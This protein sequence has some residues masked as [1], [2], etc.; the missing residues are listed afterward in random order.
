MGMALLL[1][2]PFLALILIRILWSGSTLW[3]LMAGIIFLGSSA[4]VFLARRNEP[5]YGYQTLAP[6]PNRLPLV[7]LGLGALFLALLILPNVSGDS[8]SSAS[9]LS[10]GNTSQEPSGNLLAQPT[11]RQTPQGQVTVPT[12]TARAQPTAEE[13][14]STIDTS[15]QDETD[16][17]AP[18]GSQVYVV[19]DGDT[20]W[21]IATTFSTT[22]DDILAAN[23]LENADDLQL[24]DELVIP[25]PSETGSTAVENG[26]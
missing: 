3:F 24:G 18:E 2:V 14:P 9:R 13:E 19:Q 22:V 23:D 25:P 26:E 12:A 4:I 6:E 7:L 8:G 1:A 16:G 11:A 21:D 15:S 5:S 20:L 17:S 10:T